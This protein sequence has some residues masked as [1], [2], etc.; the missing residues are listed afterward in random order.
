MTYKTELHCH[1][2]PV[3]ACGRIPVE[4]LVEM[5]LEAGYTTVVLTNHFSRYTF[6]AFVATEM[7]TWEEKVAYF[8]SDFEK[9]KAAGAGKLHVLLGMEF[10]LDAHAETDFLAYGLDETF[11]LANSDIL[12]ISLKTLSSRVRTVGGLLVQAHPFRNNVLISDPALIDG[13]EAWN[14]SDRHPSRNDMAELWADR[15]SLIKTSG[16]DLHREYQHIAGGILTDTPITTDGELLSTLRS[17]RYQ[18]LRGG[19]PREG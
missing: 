16:S 19:E 13:V 12:E 7:L 18:L 6:N 10:R 4:R 3:S 2:T 15:F 1:S 11:L 8:L 14:C 5:Y 17:G 9:M